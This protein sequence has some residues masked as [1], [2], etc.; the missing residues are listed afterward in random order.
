MTKPVG[1]LRA[2]FKLVRLPNLFTLP[3]DIAVGF[4][5]LNPR[6]EPAF[7]ALLTIS[8]LLYA[9]GSITN[10]VSDLNEDRRL[11]PW[12]PL[13]RGDISRRAAA[14]AAAVLITAAVVLAGIVGVGT[15]WMTILLLILII[16]YNF[17]TR[18]FIFPGFVNMSLC[19]MMNILLGA[20]VMLG[21]VSWQLI[22]F[23][24]IEG[25]Y[26]FAISFLAHLESRYEKLSRTVTL[27]L[28]GIIPLQALFLL[29]GGLPVHALAILALTPIPW[30][31]TR[32]GFYAT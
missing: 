2:W 12:R 5:L 26:I 13:V 16:A 25:V 29:V 10:D 30:I 14:T 28:N 3:G 4:F 20:S 32:K 24:L 17:L 1:N 7:F 11:K 23:I 15:F 18:R 9:T 22:V 31:L 19:R 27:M 6:V 21:A 8:V